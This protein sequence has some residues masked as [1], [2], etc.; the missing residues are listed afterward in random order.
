MSPD[1]ANELEPSTGLKKLKAL[2]SGQ[3]GGSAMASRSKRDSL[4][5]AA[6]PGTATPQLGKRSRAAT[7]QFA[8]SQDPC[9]DINRKKK[10]PDPPKPEIDES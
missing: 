7:N 2:A 6:E 9:I 10:Q 1:V 4:T 5:L 8:P 3:H